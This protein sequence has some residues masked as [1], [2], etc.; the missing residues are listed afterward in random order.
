MRCGNITENMRKILF[1]TCLILFFFIF[2]SPVKAE[3]ITLRKNGEVI[4]NVLSYQDTFGVAKKESLEIKDVLNSQA[5]EIKE[6]ILLAKEGGEY[7][8]NIF[9]NEGSKELNVTNINGDLVEI[10]E[11]PSVKNLKIGL[12]DGNFYLEE[13]GIIAK[14]IFP[15]NIDT[16]NA[17]ISVKTESGD[18]FIAVSPVDAYKYCLRAKNI[19]KLTSEDILITEK[20]LGEIAY[21]I[22]GEKTLN[23]FGLINYDVPVRVSVSTLTGEITNIETEVWMKVLTFFF[24]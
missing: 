12:T 3:I 10:E 14:T 21:E 4:I 6:T 18:H 17:E 23:F 1:T 11:R 16:K 2:F 5:S 7:K 20:N 24:G 19:S 9:S 8:L 15:I 13:A 22:P